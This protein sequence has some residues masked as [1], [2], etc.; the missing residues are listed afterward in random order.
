MEINLPQLNITI[1][2]LTNVVVVEEHYP[3]IDNLHASLADLLGPPKEIACAAPAEIL[4]PPNV[5]LGEIGAGPCVPLGEIG[6]GPSQAIGI[7][8]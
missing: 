5:P 4:A 1:D 6:A 7:T 3:F 8:A 2:T